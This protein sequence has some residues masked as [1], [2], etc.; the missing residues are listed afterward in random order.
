M[1]NILHLQTNA[2]LYH[3]DRADLS[4]ANLRGANLSKANLAGATLS[5]ANL[6]LAYLLDATYDERTKWPG[7]LGRPLSGTKKF[8]E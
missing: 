8:G 2:V 3:T 5:N 7:I 1:I 4:G 6:K